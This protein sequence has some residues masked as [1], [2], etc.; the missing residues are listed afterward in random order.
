MKLYY[1]PGACSM[2]PHTALQWIGKPYEARGVR[3]EETKTPEYLKLNPQGAVPLL[4]DGDLV[5]SQNVAILSYL[6][7]R[8]PE[9]RLF[10]SDQI[11]ARAQAMRWLAF[12]NADVHKAFGPLFRSSPAVK[13][14][15]TQAALQDE[16]RGRIVGMLA[17][18]ND[19]LASHRWLGGADISVADI[20]LY[21]ILRWCHGLKID[22][23]ALTHL[24]PFYERVGANP[25]VKEVIAQE[26]IEA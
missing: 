25:A 6:D 26:G 18:A 19:R 17:Q 5:L 16:A 9:A 13:D 23:S 15:A 7:A 24:K 8:F 1:L 4:E 11:P 3:F 12:L 2:V 21:V 14:E 10:G 20:Y 22:V